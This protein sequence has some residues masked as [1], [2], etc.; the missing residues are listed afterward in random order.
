L[1]AAGGTIGP[2]YLAVVSII[3][4]TASLLRAWSGYGR[5]IISARELLS[6]P[7]YVARKLPL[8]FDFFRRRER[9]WVRTAR[10][11]EHGEG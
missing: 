2:L 8:Y 10:D 6:I 9:D 7:L 1:A 5:D 4:A 3:L 11:D